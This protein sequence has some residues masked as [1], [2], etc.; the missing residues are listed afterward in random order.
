MVG[1]LLALAL[2]LSPAWTTLSNVFLACCLLARLSSLAWKCCSATL[3]DLD[4]CLLACRLLARLSSLAWK[5][6]SA[7]LDDIVQC[8][9]SLPLIGSPV[10]LGLEVLFSNLGRPCPMSSQLAAYWLACPPWP[11][12]VVQQ[13]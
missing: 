5:C 10:L 1:L 13:P 7:T 9:P 2:I 3:D 12:S 11:G 4:Q 6:C 8:L